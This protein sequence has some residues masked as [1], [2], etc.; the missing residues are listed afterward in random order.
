M[1][2]KRC[3]KLKEYVEK[4]IDNWFSMKPEELKAEIER[5]E[6][7]YQH[8]FYL[9]KVD[10]RS[11]SHSDWLD[12]VIKYRTMKYFHETYTKLADLEKYLNEYDGLIGGK[13]DCK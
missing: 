3:N 12:D 5:L 6:I 8:A 7:K 2:L 1:F 11:I 4:T 13:Y 9:D 10:L